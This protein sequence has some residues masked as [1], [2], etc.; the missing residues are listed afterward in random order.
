MVAE[1]KRILTPEDIAQEL[2][3]CRKSV[4]TMLKKGEIPHV[5]CGD[6]YLIPAAAFSKW[7]ECSK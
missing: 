5:K 2:G 1:A 6:R 3:I 4:Y 7:L